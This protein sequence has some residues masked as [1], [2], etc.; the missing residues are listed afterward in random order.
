MV[1]GRSTPPAGCR[2]AT[3]SSPLCPAWTCSWT[4]PL[5]PLPSTLKGRRPHSSRS[6]PSC[7]SGA[8][9][10]ASLSRSA[11]CSLL[12]DF[13][14]LSCQLSCKH[15]L[16]SISFSASNILSLPEGFAV[17]CLQ[18]TC[19]PAL[20]PLLHCLKSGFSYQAN[21]CHN[22]ILQQPKFLAQVSRCCASHHWAG[23]CSFRCTSPWCPSM[24]TK[25]AHASGCNVRNILCSLSTEGSAGNAPLCALSLCKLHAVCVSVSTAMFSAGHWVS[26][27]EATAKHGAFPTCCM[28]QADFIVPSSREA[29]DCDSAWNELL[30]EQ[31]PNLFLQALHSFKKLDPAHADLPMAWVNRWLQSIPLPREVHPPPPL[32]P[33]PP[34]PVPPPP[35]QHPHTHVSS[36]GSPHHAHTCILW[37]RLVEVTCCCCSLIATDSTHSFIRMLMPACPTS[38]YQQ[39]TYLTADD[40][41][42]HK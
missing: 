29:V 10:S 8:M 27:I 2:L 26:C 5:F 19:Q 40:F 25:H 21:I 1:P 12:S 37:A 30:R 32:A 14:M 39:D 15:H 6:M 28:L 42:A 16:A 41:P 24:P 11:T 7:P 13:A 17:A 4:R 18:T 22:A 33:P 20:W 9:D 3:P 36:R 38:L 35:T 23:W 34:H 31:V